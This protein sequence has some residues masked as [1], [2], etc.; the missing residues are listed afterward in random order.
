MLVPV[1]R[2]AAPGR[3][4]GLA[5]SAAALLG[6][7]VLPS[8]APQE[9]G[10]AAGASD[11]SE[12][13][14]ATAQEPATPEAGG[15]APTDEQREEAR[16]L[17]KRLPATHYLGLPLDDELSGRVLERYLDYLD[18]ARM[19]LRAS[20]VAAF[21]SHRTRLDEA[22]RAGELDAGYEMFERFQALRLARL[23][24]IAA[25]AAERVLALDL[26]DEE[27]LV[28]DREVAPWA[29]S[30]AE[31]DE[32]WRK[33]LEAET[34]ELLLQG[35][36]RE[37][38]AETIQRRYENL[39]N[40]VRQTRGDDV[41]QIFMNSFAVSYDPHTQYL[42]RKGSQDFDVQMSL[43]LEG[44]GALLRSDGEYTLVERLVAA[45]PAEKG[46][47]LKPG[48]RIL[49]VAQ[50]AEGEF[51]D[52]IGWRIDEVVDLIR[53]PRDTTVR[54][55][56]LPA[57][58]PEGAAAETI[59]IVRDEV[60]LEE[61]AARK[62]IVELG[63]GDDAVR[64][65]V[66]EL[67]AFYMDFAA[68]GKGDPDFKSSTRDVE[69]LLL[70]LQ[71]EDV[72]GILLDLRGNGGGSLMEAHDLSGLF[73]GRRPV[74]QVR[75][76][77]GS[78]QVLGGERPAVYS[79]PL[80]VLVD[81]LSASA[82]EIFAGAVQDYGRGVVVGERTF[83][84]GTVQSVVPIGSGRLLLTVAKFYRIT[85]ESTQ[86]AGVTPD[87][88]FPPLYDPEVIGESA[89]EGALLADR[90][91]P[92]EVARGTTV[93]ELLDELQRAHVERIDDDPDFVR[94]A[95]EVELLQEASRRTSISLAEAQRRAERDSF[96][97]RSE[98]IVAAWREA[99]GLPP[100][101]DDEEQAADAD[102]PLADAAPA[103]GAEGAGETVDDDRPDAA[104]KEAL[105]LLAD[106][107]EELSPKLVRSGR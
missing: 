66:I 78:V 3:A 52:V 67:P 62:E 94:L 28:V 29:A 95:R 92:L 22:I 24:A 20:D 68:F 34:L 2:S 41:F 26:T 87:I 33:R 69:R 48:D 77:D 72:D 80:I 74:V 30:D 61:Q 107:V 82:S 81:R 27:A 21:E 104:R 6:L 60:K 43:S 38:A 44:I 86:H 49:A 54:L 51:V 40:Q 103:E 98:A 57:A 9:A 93:P 31:L 102:E 14:A 16:R 53:G 10:R 12:T 96:Q 85:G 90:I 65:G 100:L 36:T 25:D 73:L 5:A 23:E 84:K 42:A 13:G 8:L 88:S 50:G 17:A 32:L 15:F 79:G 75:D 19:Y 45:G 56:V 83:G 39:L 11:P 101:P 35:R 7:L 63:E 58:A 105:N 99:R 76:A 59:S 89:L 4:R 46:G 37:Q 55:R 91:P 106:L 18:P 70:E 71:Q 97:S 64:L 47:D 1:Q